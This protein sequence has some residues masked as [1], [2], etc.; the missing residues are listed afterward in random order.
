MFQVPL[1]GNHLQLPAFHTAPLPGLEGGKGS[2][3]GLLQ[4]T[5]A[6]ALPPRRIFSQGVRKRG[7]MEPRK[8]GQVCPPPLMSNGADTQLLPHCSYLASG[9]EEAQLELP[10]EQRELLSGAPERQDG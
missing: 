6:R 4:E 10:E 5:A 1:G 9:E 8:L 7:Y 2:H 3:S